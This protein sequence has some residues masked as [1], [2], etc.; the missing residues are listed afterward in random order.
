MS[1]QL[2]DAVCCAVHL[3]VVST[4]DDD[5]KMITNWCVNNCLLCHVPRP[6][7]RARYRWFPE[8]WEC[9]SQWSIDLQTAPTHSTPPPSQ[10]SEPVTDMCTHQFTNMTWYTMYISK[11]SGMDHTVLPANTPC[12]PFLRMRS[13]D[14]ATVNWGKSHPIAAYCSSI[15]PEG[16]KGYSL[17]SLSATLEEILK[18]AKQH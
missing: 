10:T 7:S 11:R 3:R 16:I 17:L 14:G 12:L 8:C 13:P 15:D 5:N 2:Q 1:K 9:P 6:G 4:L 18:I